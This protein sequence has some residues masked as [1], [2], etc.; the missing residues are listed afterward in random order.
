MLFDLLSSLRSNNDYLTDAPQRRQVCHTATDWPNPLS[1]TKEKDRL[2]SGLGFVVGIG[3]DAL[4]R[5]TP[6]PSARRRA[7]T[8]SSRGDS[9][10]EAVIDEAA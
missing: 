1:A 9:N 7:F 3:Y 10:G 8:K 4:R 2:K 5:L 6:F